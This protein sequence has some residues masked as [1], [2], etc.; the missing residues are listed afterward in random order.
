[1]SVQR[2]FLAFLFAAAL[3]LIVGLLVDLRRQLAVERDHPARLVG[4]ASCW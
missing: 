2:Y 1:M 3:T 4:G